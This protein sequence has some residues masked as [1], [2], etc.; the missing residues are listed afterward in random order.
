M[1]LDEKAEYKSKHVRI[2]RNVFFNSLCSIFSES[3]S[4]VSAF[5]DPVPHKKVQFVIENGVIH[6]FQGDV[7]RW[8]LLITSALIF[9]STERLDT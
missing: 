4:P 3:T 6:P 7:V 8:E 2:A 9:L 1:K 5:H